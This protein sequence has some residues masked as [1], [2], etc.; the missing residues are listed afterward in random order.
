MK[1][2]ILIGVVLIILGVIALSYHGITYKTRE[3]VLKIGPLEATKETEKTI[4]FPPILGG[5]ALGAGIVLVIV[6]FRGGIGR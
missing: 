3:Q 5:V 4:A 1:L 2:I 6:G